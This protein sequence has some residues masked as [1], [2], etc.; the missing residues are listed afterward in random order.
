MILPLL[1][2]F[3]EFSYKEQLSLS[4]SLFPWK[5]ICSGKIGQM[6]D[7]ILYLWLQNKEWLPWDR[8][9]K[10]IVVFP[11][12]ITIN[13]EILTYLRS[14]WGASCLV[15][16]VGFEDISKRPSR[17]WLPFFL[18]EHDFSDSSCAVYRD[19]SFLLLT[20]VFRD[21]VT[22]TGGV[23]CSLIS[24]SVDKARRN[25]VSYVS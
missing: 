24:L 13:S 10:M 11:F 19:P 23:H 9:L 21:H 2:H 8:E 5:E 7:H 20:V 18:V 16:T 1:L 15:F 14:F 25:F 12:S 4:I 22:G 6:F 3:T 17:P